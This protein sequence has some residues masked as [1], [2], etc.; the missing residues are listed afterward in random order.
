M[1]HHVKNHISTGSSIKCFFFKPYSRRPFLRCFCHFAQRPLDSSLLTDFDK[2]SLA[3]CHLQV[4]KRSHVTE[5]FFRQISHLHPLYSANSVRHTQYCYMNINDTWNSLRMQCVS[6]GL[7]GYFSHE[8]NVIGSKTRLDGTTHAQTIS[9]REL[10][11]GHAVGFGQM[12]S[13]KKS[14]EW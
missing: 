13:R 1:P 10:F 3:I 6:I 7:L 8:Q 5:G 2:S 12:K 9:C 14:I 11:A 4:F